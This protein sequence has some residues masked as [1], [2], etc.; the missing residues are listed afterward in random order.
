MYALCMLALRELFPISAQGETTG[1]QAHIPI[2]GG[3]AA[4]FPRLHPIVD[5][6][7]LANLA[8][9]GYLSKC[10]H[11]ASMEV[12]M[13]TLTIKGLP[14]QIYRKLKQLA[15]SQRRSINSQAILCL[16][17]VLGAPR[18]DPEGFLAQV[19]ALRARL[20]CPPVS[21]EQIDKD[22]RSGRS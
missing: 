14:E 9:P 16:E 15:A 17:Q 18:V 8:S 19:D 12:P 11:R 10:I 1:G 4:L 22:K 20:T 3:S 7:P 6:T 5:H 13:A 2:P 21:D